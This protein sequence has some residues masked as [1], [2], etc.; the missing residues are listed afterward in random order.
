MRKL[1][2]FGL[3]QVTVDPSAKHKLFYSSNCRM[4]FPQLAETDQT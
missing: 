1:G 2:E 4:I 3:T